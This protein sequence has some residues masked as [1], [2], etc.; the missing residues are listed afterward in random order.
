MLARPRPAPDLDGVIDLPAG[1]IAAVATYLD[2]RAPRPVATGLPDAPAGSCRLEPLTGDVARYRRLYADVGE[3]WLWFS[4]ALLDDRRLR[5]I[6]DDPR[7][8]A[9][10]VT[11]DGADIGLVELDFRQP[12]VCELAFFGL[13]S[14]AVGHGLGRHLIRE[15]IRRAFARPIDRLWLHTCTLDHPSAVRFYMEAGFRPYRRAIEIADDPRLAGQL[16]RDAGPGLPI[17]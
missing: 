8:D 5:A 16:P 4:R 1:K 11:V 10:A 7:V 3:R 12:R 9:L 2:M 6:I 15:A 13:V 17:V 14:R